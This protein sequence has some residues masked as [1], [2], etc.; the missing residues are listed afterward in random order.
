MTPGSSRLSILAPTP[1]VCTLLIPV[2]PPLPDEMGPLFLGLC[3]WKGHSHLYPNINA[4]VSRP[5]CYIRNTWV[6][7]RNDPHWAPSQSIKSNP[8]GMEPAHQNPRSLSGDS[9]MQSG[10]GT[11]V[12]LAQVRTCNTFDLNCCS[13]HLTP[14]EDFGWDFPF[15][16]KAFIGW[17]NGLGWR[18]MVASLIH[19]NQGLIRKECGGEAGA[20]CWLLFFL[21]S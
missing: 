18:R 5:G 19:T 1:E 6:A 7:S 15:S 21:F 2:Y 14:K 17:G 20:G 11:T 3:Y 4:V 10:L 12:V 9:H 13:Q 8:V 16:G